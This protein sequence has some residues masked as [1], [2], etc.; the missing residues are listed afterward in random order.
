MK[1]SVIWIGWKNTCAEKSEESKR[2]S[3]EIT[4]AQVIAA[5]A[6]AVFNTGMDPHSSGGSWFG[7]ADTILNPVVNSF[8]YHPVTQA[9]RTQPHYGR[10]VR[11]DRPYRLEYTWVSKTIKG[12]E[13]MVALSFKA[14]RNKT[15]VT[16]RHSSVPDDEEGCKHKD[17][18]SFVKF[19]SRP[20]VPKVT[21]KPPR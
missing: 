10:F 18:W 8:F 16:L 11:I 3:P 15:E 21:E 13:S 7:S 6:E 4:V 20:N 14:N 19:A 9:G 1:R 2:N 12:A 5:P 17:G